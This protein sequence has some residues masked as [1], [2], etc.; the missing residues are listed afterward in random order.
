[1]FRCLEI[2]CAALRIRLATNDEEKLAR[3]SLGQAARLP[4]RVSLSK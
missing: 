3:G 2:W 1:M 4:G